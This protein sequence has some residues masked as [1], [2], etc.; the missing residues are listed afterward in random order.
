MKTKKD[1]EK[2]KH[3]F[4]TEYGK[5]R[6]LTS[7]QDTTLKN[8]SNTSNRVA[9]KGW[10]WIDYWRAMTDDANTTL[11]CSSCGKVIYVGEIPTIIKELYLLTDDKPENHKALGGHVWV[12]KPSK[13]NYEGGIYITPLCPECNNKRDESIPVL[14]GTKICKELGAENE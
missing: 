4:E 12:N 9:P 3:E 8:C 5:C 13:G 6:I 10:S 2:Y 14:K 7:N 11:T 1:L